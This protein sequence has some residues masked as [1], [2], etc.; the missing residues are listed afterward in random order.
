MA[1]RAR[2]AAGVGAAL[3]L[4]ALARAPAAV[5]AAA[6]AASATAPLGRA[7]S[8]RARAA[9]A[10]VARSALADEARGEGPPAAAAGAYAPPS[11]LNSY[12]MPDGPPSFFSPPDACAEHAARLRARVAAGAAPPRPTLVYVPGI[13]LSGYT[14][15][16]QL[17]RLEPTYDVRVLRVA[18][19]D[20]TPAPELSALVRE[21]VARLRARGSRVVLMGE[22]FG[23]VVAL[24]AA[25]TLG[26]NGTDTGLACLVLINPATVIGRTPWPSL[27][28]AL[29]QLPA[30]L[31]DAL[32]GVLSPLLANPLRL[33]DLRLDAQPP[34][35]PADAGAAEPAAEGT[36]AA[37]APPPPA[38]S[39]DS[40]A[41]P[42]PIG[43]GAGAGAGAGSGAG[44]DAGAAGWA[45]PQL[46]ARR[47]GEM[48]PS[49][50]QL[51]RALPQRTL[52]FRLRQLDEHA[53]AVD[54]K[55]WSAVR[56]PALVLASTADNVLPAPQAA[57]AI[58][59][60]L[61]GA[62]V[63]LLEGAG[64]APLIETA[65]DLASIFERER[66][67]SM[68]LPRQYDYV[69][70]FTHPTD[71]QVEAASRALEPLRR[72][73]SPR[74]FSTLPSGQRVPGLSALPKPRARGGGAT[75]SLDRPVLFVGNHQ[76]FGV[77]DL[78]LLVEEL[79]VTRG[80]LARGLAHP[81]AFRAG[82]PTG[83]EPTAER[84]PNGGVPGAGEL[85]DGGAAGGAAGA[86]GGATRTAVPPR[87][88]GGLA[89]GGK[90]GALGGSALDFATFG[91]VPVSARNLLRLL[92]RNEAALLY[93]GG[94]REAFK[95]K[96][97][98]YRLFWPEADG[99]S[100][101]V[102]IAAR[103]NALVIPVAAVGAED[104]VELLADSDEILA[105]PAGIG[106][107]VRRAA[108]GVP[109][110]RAGET[111]VTPLALPAL[112]PR[113]YY[114]CFGRPL[115]A[116]SL[117]PRDAAASAAAY[118]EVR[119]ELERALQW[120]LQRREDDPYKEFAPRVMYEAA[121]EWKRQAPTFRL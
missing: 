52:A 26:A 93:P 60:R 92:Q 64:H 45:S 78:P 11:D 112:P 76:L 107:A 116:G 55:D 120:L 101:F 73:V 117:D 17:A 9:A 94:I 44:A 6:A 103:A 83:A 5:I 75:P 8:T 62:R 63:R 65:V 19:D 38:A 61:L 67:L 85:R 113:R 118:R 119:A 18:P 108:E 30:S 16:K 50:E 71:E 39:A 86:R 49:L 22:S 29:E 4:L 20:R 34:A 81:V 54:R 90:G 89:A 10:R 74:F 33:L 70:S 28:S 80:I 100:D 31:Y 53:A 12:L 25:L 111:F 27:A 43:A 46:I 58:A 87:N 69:T 48:L 3:S 23:G 35:T 36:A 40:S 106:D 57:R 77:T 91:A 14:L 72:L 32:P 97:E 24:D 82:G 41:G 66:V 15:S 109:R 56:V 104:G 7:R 95:R 37:A 121:A 96:G 114:F 99:A 21:E 105:L 2:A 51:P 79:L 98:R 13:E 88:L 47:L 68:P 1:R 42:P 84:A 110:A 115:D 102:R 59:S